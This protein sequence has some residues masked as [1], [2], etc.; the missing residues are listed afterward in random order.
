MNQAQ[1]LHREAMSLVDDALQAKR[2]GNDS[3]WN[4]ILSDAFH[5]EQEA[6]MLFMNEVELEPTR[7][8]LFRSAASLA[9][10][11]MKYRDA[12]KLIAIGLSGEPPDE[13]AEEMRDLLEDVNAYR[14]L[15]LRGVE[16]QSNEFQLSLAGGSEVGY[17]FVSSKEFIDRANYINSLVTRI[18]DWKLNEPFLE[19]GSRKKKIEVFYSMPRAASFAISL[20]LATP[21]QIEQ[22]SIPGVDF[23]QEIM[24][25]FFKGLE[26]INDNN[27][28]SLYAQFNDE[29]YFNNF[30]A[31]VK[32]MR[33]DG[34][35]V[36]SVG[37]TMGNKGEERKVL[38][39]SPEV[40]KEKQKK[41]KT[42]TE[43]IVI[44]GTLQWA[45]ATHEK[46]GKIKLI[47]QGGASHT[48]Q[49]PRH[50]M[51]DIV[52]PLFEELVI[53]TAIRKGGTIHL[54]DI[55]RV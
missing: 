44:E 43:E 17:G 55:H 26:L 8:V 42:P 37:F 40:K 27:M 6:A 39:R 13:I 35:K 34:E 22:L 1:I 31:L 10:D 16:L 4:N 5:K 41:E 14:H 49:V 20:R 18:T 19:R 23:G 15:S 33:P 52:K 47:D 45:D 32:Q 11:C 46:A 54:E 21:N 24:E 38:L 30:V 28:E 53:V 51:S 48:V 2:D 3:K 9:I 7:S 50:M 12:E 25:V 29:Q 36:H